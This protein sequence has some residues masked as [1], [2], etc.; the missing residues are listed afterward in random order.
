MKRVIFFLMLT[1]ILT[2]CSPRKKPAVAFYYW[3][4]N[5]ELSQ[6]EKQLLNHNHVSALYIRYFDIGLHPKSATPYPVSPVHF[7]EKPSVAV[8]PVV[9]IKNEVFLQKDPDV[10]DLVNKTLDYIRQINVKNAIQINEIQI[11]CDWTIS[12]R[13]RYLDFM[14]VLKAQCGT[15]LSATIRL[16]QVKYY[17]K[18][19]IPNVD[20]GVLMYYNMGKIAPDL[21]HSIYDSNIANRY[22]K[23]L[24]NY[25]LP[26]D[27]ALPIYSWAIHIRDHK[28]IGLKSKDQMPD[29]ENP[30]D[31]VIFDKI[32]FRTLRSHYDN[33]HFYRKGDVLKLEK[34]NAT[35]L[36]E[37]AVALGESLRNP[38]ET[39]LFYDLDAF[40]TKTYEKGFF[41]TIA[42]D[43]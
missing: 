23:S 19:K 31:F 3:K 1:A 27:V 40:N 29:F 37:M 4:T 33:G 28:V 43:F 22:L 2:G 32:F 41:E 16:H 20:K 7:A 21:L 26:L 36:K 35:D 17:E 39:I 11:D 6:T 13:D 34:I 25:P 12:S 5:F 8:V 38:P 15:R 24:K 30:S 18:T 10:K 42:G 9:Y 14:D